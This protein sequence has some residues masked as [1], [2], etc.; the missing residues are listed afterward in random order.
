M[1]AS[2]RAIQKFGH[3]LFGLS[4]GGFLVYGL[5]FPVPLDF[6]FSDRIFSGKADPGEAGNAEKGGA[7]EKPAG[8][9]R[10]PFLAAVFAAPAGDLSA[11]AV[12]KGFVQGYG[13][14]QR[15]GSG[16]YIGQGLGPYQA[17]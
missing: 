15:N 8:M 17:L 3:R 1:G 9:D 4:G 2:S 13:H 7:R 10:A 6:P 16:E 12:V 5:F 14:K 11:A